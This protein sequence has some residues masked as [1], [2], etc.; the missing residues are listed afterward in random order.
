VEDKRRIEELKRIKEEKNAIEKENKRLIEQYLN[1]L[2]TYK[3]NKASYD[4]ILLQLAKAVKA[5]K[6]KLRDISEL[7]EKLANST[8]LKLTTEQK[9]KIKSKLS[10]EQKLQ[11]AENEYT[12]HMNTAQSVNLTPPVELSHELM[13]MIESIH[14]S[15]KTAGNTTTA[16][17]THISTQTSPHSTSMIRTSQ[18]STDITTATATADDTVSVSIKT[19]TT[20]STTGTLVQPDSAVADSSSTLNISNTSTTDKIHSKSYV[21]TVNIKVASSNMSNNISNNITST[22]SNNANIVAP[23]T[24]VKVSNNNHSSEIEEW[25]PV[26][27][28]KKGKKK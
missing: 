11:T 19:T 17:A 25:A 20:T 3:Q 8:T 1:R 7:E 14:I 26:T 16:N 2:T 9:E 27:S 18:Q 5:L 21:T 15:H 13:S 22:T 24:P 28:S 23:S 4:D 10:I 12:N 6:K